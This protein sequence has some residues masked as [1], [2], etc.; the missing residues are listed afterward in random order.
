MGQGIEYDAQSLSCKLIGDKDKE[1]GIVRH[2][3]CGP[4]AF[5]IASIILTE[6]FQVHP[7]GDDNYL[8]AGGSVRIA[9]FPFHSCRNSDDGFEP[10]VPEY[11]FLVPE[12]ESVGHTEVS[13]DANRLR[14]TRLM[15]E[16]G[17]VAALERN[18][19]IGAGFGT[20]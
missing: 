2:V 9:E 6:F 16:S 10:A 17:E 4:D 20:V 8:V 5:S 14:E 18:D 3:V 1:K 13:P 7:I 19:I 15:F 11:P 12:S